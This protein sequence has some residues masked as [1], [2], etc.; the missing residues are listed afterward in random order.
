MYIYRVFLCSYQNDII[1]NGAIFTAIS[2]QCPLLDTLHLNID[3]RK[4][5]SS[6]LDIGVLGL[7]GFSNIAEFRFDGCWNSLSDEEY[8][9]FVS[10]NPSL[11]ILDL[12]IDTPN[13]TSGNNILL[14][15][16]RNL[17]VLRLRC[18]IS[19]G[20]GKLS[21]IKT[22]DTYLITNLSRSLQQTYD[23]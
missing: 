18:S 20:N 5:T 19:N 21:Q 3:T 8:Y 17:Q 22:C 4:M 9:S 12:N 6:Y 23:V 16:C 1:G 15:N 7:D 10:R 2:K 11:A 13:N 14:S